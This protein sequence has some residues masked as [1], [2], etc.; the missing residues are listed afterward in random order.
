MIVYTPEQIIKACQLMYR[1]Y[2]KPESIHP[3]PL[4]IP[5]LFSNQKDQEIAG[6]FSAMVAL[7][8]VDLFMPVVHHVF[9]LFNKP[10]EQLSLL[11]YRDILELLKPTYYR[12]FTPQSLA[13]LL[14]A[15]VSTI[16][17]YGS[18]EACYISV[19]QTTHL[20]RLTYLRETILTASPVP[21]PPITIPHPSGVAKRLH[22]FARW[23][24]RKDQIDLGVWSHGNP[25][26]LFYPLDTH[27]F[28]VAKFLSITNR[29]S[30]DVKALI[31]V[32]EFFRTWN[33]DDPVK[34]DF[35]LSRIG[36]GRGLKIQEYEKTIQKYLE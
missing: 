34:F 25:Q 2:H 13:G 16:K 31:E 6:F 17:T 36:L 29:K 21:L 30:A 35:S 20:K 8:R 10:A 26:D 19:P 1:K 4:E 22:L 18:L 14:F 24:I 32:S 27:I 9:S 15:I 7:G 23:M 28:Q 5:R 33:P 11:T 12:F 3:D